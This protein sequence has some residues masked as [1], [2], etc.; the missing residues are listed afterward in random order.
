L[1]SLFRKNEVECFSF[2]ISFFSWVLLYPINLTHQTPR[3]HIISQYST[4][5]KITLDYSKSH[6]ITS[7]HIISYCASP[8]HTTIH[9][10]PNMPSKTHNTHHHT[11]HILLERCHEDVTGECRVTSFHLTTPPTCNLIARI[12][13]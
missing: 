3:H 6:R 13:H 10:T 11:H 2:L 12:F 1:S 4:H 7:Y 5:Q 8:H 9:P